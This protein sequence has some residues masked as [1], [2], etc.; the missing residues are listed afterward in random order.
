MYILHALIL[1]ILSYKSKYFPPEQIPDNNSAV[2][3]T[4]VLWSKDIGI[5]KQ[6]VCF[7]SHAYND[8]AKRDFVIFTTMPWEDHEIAELQAV[9][10]PSNL[11]VA[12]E[13][14]PLEEQLAAMTKEEVTFLRER[15]GAKENDTL[16]WFHHCTEPGS[17]NKAN[18]GYSWQAEFRSY[19]IWT[20][21]ALKNYRYMMWIDSDARI[22]AKWEVDPIDAMIENDLTL[23]YAQFPYGSR[24]NDVEIGNK[25]TQVYNTS[26]CGVYADS[27]YR[28]IYAKVCKDQ[29]A[30]FEMLGGMHHITDLD[31][32]RNDIHQQFLKAFTGD[33]RF[34]RKSDDQMAVTLVAV[35][36]QYLQNKESTDTHKMLTWHERSRNMTLKI[37]HHKTYDGARNER[38]AANRNNFYHAVKNN[39]TGLEERCGAFH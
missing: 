12:L 33:Y 5:L 1:F 6:W 15:C 31:V 23:L 22:G 4:K 7:I 10:A 25:L 30:S 20:H 11:T 18:L 29:P 2:I 8:K 16:T 38:C 26:L 39:F 32:Y 9:A 17:N 37:C 24:K 28:H 36:E 13:A 19:Q 14:P 34:S 21:P 27:K 35:M 3:V